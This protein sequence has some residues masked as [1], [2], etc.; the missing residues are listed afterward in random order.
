MAPANE[1]I[2]FYE[3]GAR[4]TADASA[5]ITGCR[6]V[7]VSGDREAGPNLNTNTTG[8]NIRCA[9]AGAGERILGVASHDVAQEGKVTVLTG[10]VVP[11]LASG[12]IAAGAEVKV[13]A[14]GVAVTS[15]TTAGT[16]VVGMCMSAAAD[17]ELAQ[18][19]L[20]G[21]PSRLPA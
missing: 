18:I 4:I 21:A 19:L 6:F 20:Y 11:V 3:P 1:C 14:N 15:G 7:K 2:P 13:G 12:A 9:H 10:G 5:A 17:G 16:V 8:G